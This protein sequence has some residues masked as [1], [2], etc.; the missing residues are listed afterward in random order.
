ML[1]IL[2]GLGNSSGSGIERNVWE[3]LANMP[4]ERRGAVMGYIDGVIYVHGGVYTGGI[5]SNTLYAFDIEAGT[6]SN[7]ATGP[8]ARTNACG[9][10]LDGYFYIF[11]GNT[12]TGIA[13]DLWRYD[14]TTNTWTQLTTANTPTARSQ[15]CIVGYNG[16]LYLFG[17]DA[18]TNAMNILDL[19]TNTWSVG[20]AQPAMRYQCKAAVTAEGMIYISGGYTTTFVAEFWR[21]N[22]A[23]NAWTN[24]TSG[25]SAR[26]YHGSCAFNGK[27]Y[28]I[29]GADTGSSLT[30]AHEYN[31]N[32]NV[33]K[34][35]KNLPRAGNDIVVST[36]GSYIYFAGGVISTIH[37]DAW[38]LAPAL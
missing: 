6:W 15:A 17:G 27:V 34:V 16:K 28:V 9:C 32:T 14:P 20:A 23:G 1:E 13:N 36:D 25:F 33:W 35:V 8:N 30:T 7:K 21:Y 4:G 3:Q 22:I 18:G 38:R 10:T 37:S 5:R 2:C 24:L 26:A 12:A 31:V 11:G 29:G 19:S